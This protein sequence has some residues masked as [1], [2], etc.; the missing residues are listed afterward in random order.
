M[1]TQF[2]ADESLAKVVVSDNGSGIPA[3]EL[4]KVFTIFV[5][6]KGSRGTGLGLP[7]SQKILHEH[8][9]QILVES[10]PDRG[11]VFTLEFPA[12][13]VQRSVP[14]ATADTIA[15]APHSAKD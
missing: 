7:V 5:S 1:A 11:S 10:E 12:T 8:G 13:N 2:D 15:Q 14:P 3:D 6:N 4:A 9:G